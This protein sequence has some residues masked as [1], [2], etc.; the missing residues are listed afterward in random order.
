MQGKP[1]PRERQKEG[2]CRRKNAEKF[3]VLEGEKAKGSICLYGH[4]QWSV[5]Q[6]FQPP[7][8]NRECVLK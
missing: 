3:R 6:P 1:E 7:K 2:G 8:N 4:S 5:L